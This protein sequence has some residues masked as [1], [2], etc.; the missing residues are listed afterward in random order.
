MWIIKE[1]IQ[2]ADLQDACDAYNSQGHCCLDIFYHRMLS[3]NCWKY[4]VTASLPCQNLKWQSR[5]QI[6]ILYLFC[7]QSLSSY[8]KSNKGYITWL[9]SLMCW[10]QCNTWLLHSGGVF[11]GHFN[12]CKKKKIVDHKYSNSVTTECFGSPCRWNFFYQMF[13][14]TY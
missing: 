13:Q 6:N 9:A 4:L 3:E 5:K 11:E 8:S 10:C 12:E 14:Y 1:G 7:Y 2:S